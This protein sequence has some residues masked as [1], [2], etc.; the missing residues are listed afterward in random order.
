MKY[1]PPAIEEVLEKASARW[2]RLLFLRKTA[3]LA[4]VVSSIILLLGIGMTLGWLTSPTWMIVCFVVLGLATLF[5]WILVALT[6][7]VR[8]VNRSRLAASV[9]RLH[10]PL[11]DRLNTLVFLEQQEDRRWEPYAERIQQ[12]TRRVLRRQPLCLPFPATRALR[13]FGVFLTVL[14]ATILFYSHFHPWQRVRAAA[15]LEA[16]EPEQNEPLL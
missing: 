4:S 16:V 5:A 1:L 13:H 15:R 10:E 8:L 9:E 2:R 3:V 6:T 7:A 14:I 12:Q 11:Q